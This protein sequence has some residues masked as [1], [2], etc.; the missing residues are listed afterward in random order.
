MCLRF[1]FYGVRRHFVPA[2]SKLGYA[3]VFSVNRNAVRTSALPPPLSE[4]LN[5]KI[6]ADV[7]LDS[8]ASRRRQCV[9]AMIANRILEPGCTSNAPAG[10][11]LVRFLIPT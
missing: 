6:G 9:L 10:D 2:I 4:G 5:R 8:K 7:L 3:R 1:S 11:S